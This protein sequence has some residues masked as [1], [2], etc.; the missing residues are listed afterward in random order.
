MSTPDQRISVEPQKR[1]RCDSDDVTIIETA[2]HS[3]ASNTGHI[4]GDTTTVATKRPA[5]EP[6]TPDSPDE[7]ASKSSIDDDELD[8]GELDDDAD[9]DNGDCILLE[10]SI[11]VIVLDSDLDD[12]TPSQAAPVIHDP[13]IDSDVY[14]IHNSEPLDQSTG[15]VRVAANTDPLMRIAFRDVA[16]AEKLCG[17]VQRAIRNA[18]LQQQI[19]VDVRSTVDHPHELQVVE[20]VP[21]DGNESVFIIDAAPSV[22][23]NYFGASSKSNAPLAANVP[24]YEINV[25]DVYDPNTLLN[26]VDGQRKD[27]CRRVQALCFNCSGEHNMRDCTEP[28]NAQRIRDN[29]QNF[30]GGMGGRPERYHVDANQK[31][32]LLEPGVISAE[33]RAALGLRAGDLPLH[34]YR[35][36]MLGYPPAWLEMA[37]V[38]HSGLSLFGDATATSA[39]SSQNSG[40]EDNI[41][42]DL[43]KIISYP[44]FNVQPDEG[45]LDVC[46]AVRMRCSILTIRYSL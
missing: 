17:I 14:E 27:Q 33:L 30:G 36:R 25:S 6:D 20:S 12:V 43:K 2:P 29:R 23:A 16:T 21:L 18:L 8:D 19:A 11:P 39:H 15:A 10:K 28:R 1:K 44:G 34:V 37:Q 42:Y 4:V 31:Y 7:G 5:M 45:T 32:G 13:V 24:Q 38:S 40:G 22:T 35:M 9:A 3:D 46:C 41:D 26:S